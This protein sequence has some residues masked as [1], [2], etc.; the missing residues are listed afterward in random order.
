MA[1]DLNSADIECD[2]DAEDALVLK[3]AHEMFG[4]DAV[5]AIAFFGINAWFEGRDEDVAR[6]ARLVKACAN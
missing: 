1:H 4:A 5:T 2:S 6:C 3:L